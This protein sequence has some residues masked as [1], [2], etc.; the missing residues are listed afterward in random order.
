MDSILPLASLRQRNPP[1]KPETLY[2]SEAEVTN[3]PKRLLLLA[4]YEG[5]VKRVV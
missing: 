1:S 5:I 4:D 3:D 2:K